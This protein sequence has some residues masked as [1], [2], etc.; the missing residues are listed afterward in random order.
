MKILIIKFIAVAYFILISLPFTL[1]VYLLLYI[2][3]IILYLKK[4]TNEKRVFAK[5][6][7]WLWHNERRN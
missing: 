7:K 3:S 5:P 2:I 6:T 1:L 4:K